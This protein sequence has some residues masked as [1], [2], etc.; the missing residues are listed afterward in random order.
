[1]VCFI[2]EMLTIIMIFVCVINICMGKDWK[3]MFHIVNSCYFGGEEY[4]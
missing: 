4:L 3:N 2:S 1:M